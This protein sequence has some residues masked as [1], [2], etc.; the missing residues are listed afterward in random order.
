MYQ[1]GAACKIMQYGEHIPV[2][3]KKASDH[4]ILD[5]KM[6]FTCKAQWVKNGHLTPDLEDSK[7]AGV[8]SRES[9]RISLTYATIHQTQVLSADVRNSELQA[10][11]PEKHYIICGLEF[12]LENLGKRYFILRA[13]YVRKAIGRDLWHHLQ[14]CMRLWC[15]KSKASD[16]YVWMIPAKQKDVTLVHAYVLLCT[17]AFLVVS[18]NEESILK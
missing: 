9:V 13:L 18:E 15:F 11:T 3:Y 16:P 12:G 1:V 2:G 7:Y 4:I 6:D 14:S 10:P 17:D 8:V 5:V